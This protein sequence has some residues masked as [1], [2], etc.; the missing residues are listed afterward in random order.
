[1]DLCVTGRF[2][3]QVAFA[4]LLGTLVGVH[5]VADPAGP[6]RQSKAEPAGGATQRCPSISTPVFIQWRTHGVEIREMSVIL[7]HQHSVCHRCVLCFVRTD[8]TFQTNNPHRRVRGWIPSSR[9]HG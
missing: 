8:I 6:A 1:V 3:E 5:D 7:N 2:G 9:G 4:F